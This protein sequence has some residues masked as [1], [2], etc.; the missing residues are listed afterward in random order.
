MTTDVLILGGGA[1]GIATAN[2][3]ARVAPD[4]A[5]TL[6]DRRAHH[7]YAPGFLS[8]L[9]GEAELEALRRPIADLL[10]ERVEFVEGAVESIQPG[11]RTV[12]GAFGMA[13]YETLVVALGSVPRGSDDWPQTA[14]TPWT[15]DGAL[16]LRDRLAALA[17]DARVLVAATGL[18]YKCPPAPFDLA[19]RIRHAFG[20]E[21]AMA[22]P[23][24]VPLAP[25]GPDAARRMKGH[26]ERAG[27]TYHGRFETA[28]VASDRL[29]GADGTE[30]PFDQAI[31]IPPHRT[32]SALADSPLAND[33]GWLPVSYPSLRHAEFDT[34]YGVG[35]CIAPPL[36]AGF[37]GTLAVH[38]AHHVA[39]QIA[40]RVPPDAEPTMEAICFMDFGTTGS[41]MHCNFGPPVRGEGRPDCRIM[42]EMPFF[43]KARQ[44]FQDEW[45]AT[46]LRGA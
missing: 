11:D 43:Q 17:S 42:P 41:F 3:L 35:D 14:A 30:L 26:F 16:E 4:C 37:A 18:P 38:E 46:T 23:W 8:V 36:Q 6:I 27:V 39:D 24:P 21:V 31:L 32:P 25:F 28:R 34:V 29:I 33:S 40:G 10:D 44:L 20:V 15:Q 12:I 22:H 9:F 1:G 5:I 7:V 2:R 19:V 45:F 13:E